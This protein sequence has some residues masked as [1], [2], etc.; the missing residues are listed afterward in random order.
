MINL[1]TFSFL[2][3]SVATSAGNTSSCMGRGARWFRIPANMKDDT[4][5]MRHSSISY[6]LFSQRRTLKE[7]EKE[8]N[9]LT[10]FAREAISEAGVAALVAA[11]LLVPELGVASLV[12]GLAR[13]SRGI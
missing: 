6:F 11:A 8:A 4:T 13:L 9:K 2:A 12:L 7:K 1:V 10:W 3:T 5:D